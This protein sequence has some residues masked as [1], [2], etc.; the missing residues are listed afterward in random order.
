MSQRLMV[1]CK[2]SIDLTFR[3]DEVEGVI[4][5]GWWTGGI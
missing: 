5:G 3:I 1:S 4:T 2:M